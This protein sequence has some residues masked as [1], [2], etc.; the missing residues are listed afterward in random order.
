MQFDKCS[1]YALKQTL[2]THQDY[3]L[4]L[5]G[6]LCDKDHVFVSV[7]ELDD[8]ID[9]FFVNKHAF[10]DVCSNELQRLGLFSLV[11]LTNKQLELLQYMYGAETDTDMEVRCTVAEPHYKQFDEELAH[12]DNVIFAPLDPALCFNERD[13]FSSEDMDYDSP[14]IDEEL[15]CA[16]DSISISTMVDLFETTYTLVSHHHFERKVDALIPIQECVMSTTVDKP[17]KE[18][19]S[20]QKQKDGSPK[21][22]EPIID[23][24]V[25][26]EKPIPVRVDH[27]FI[28]L[29]KEPMK[30]RVDPHKCEDRQLHP[31]SEPVIDIPLPRVEYVHEPVNPPVVVEVDSSPAAKECCGGS[32]GSSS[33]PV[34]DEWNPDLDDEYVLALDPHPRL[35]GVCVETLGQSQ[36]CPSPVPLLRV[37]YDQ[38]VADTINDELAQPEWSYVRWVLTRTNDDAFYDTLDPDFEMEDPDQHTI[39]DFFNLLWDNNVYVVSMC[40]NYMIDSRRRI[41]GWNDEHF[42]PLQAINAYHAHSDEE[43]EEDEETSDEE[44]NSSEDEE[45]TTSEELDSDN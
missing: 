13:D 25:L 9:C 38:R 41:V 12:S 22:S 19:V 18:R 36:E 35:N 3:R 23:V 15:G 33:S 30:T 34:P 20:I 17:H 27:C 39:K 7:Y 4:V 45:S 1:I 32:T 37:R 31:V 42:D 14:Y 26:V 29:F 5:D 11:D 28:Q 24:P 16:G 21:V 40:P 2:E 8:M 43:D 6:S 44:S 10:F